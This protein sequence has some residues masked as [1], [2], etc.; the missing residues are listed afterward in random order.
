[1]TGMD[2]GEVERTITMRATVLVVPASTVGHFL[3]WSDG[4]QIRRVPISL[5]GLTVGRQAPSDLV[6]ASPEISRRHCRLDLDGDWA[7]V[8]DLNSTNGTFV[9]GERIVRPTRLRNGTR[10]WL[11]SVQ[12]RYERRDSVEVAREEELVAELQRA[13]DYVQ[14]ILPEP[15]VDG[16]V[17]TDWCFVPCARLGGDAFGYQ[18]L[19]D[20]TF[21]GFVLDVSGHGIG[22]AMHAANVANALRRRA[23]PGVDFRDPVQVASGLNAVF[24]MEAHNDLML[25]IWYFVYD[26]ASRTLSFCAA[27]HHPSL[28]IAGPE[29]TSL[30]HRGPAIGMLPKGKWTAGVVEVPPM[31]RLYLFSDGAFEIV[32][33]E[34]HAWQIDDLRRL[35]MAAADGS[36]LSAHAIWDAVRAAVPAGPL[37]DDF[38]VLTVTFA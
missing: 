5:A 16:P 22:S 10:L 32:D 36:P 19:D 31:A 12:L 9:D 7:S 4:E 26:L 13:A 18:F 3:T 21:A 33:S 1:M 11:G 15:I 29:A 30:W 24:P 6:I 2:D 27:G 28:L 25:T 23:L 14:A 20:T 34:S 38:S 37:E 8:T 35:I 17:R